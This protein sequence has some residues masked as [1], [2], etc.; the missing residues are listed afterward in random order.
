MQQNE[1]S[2]G[3]KRRHAIERLEPGEEERAGRWVGSMLEQM[4]TILNHAGPRQRL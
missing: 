4:E 3:E 2:R 1:P